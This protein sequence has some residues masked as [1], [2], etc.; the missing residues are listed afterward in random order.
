MAGPVVL[1]RTVPT[2]RSIVSAAWAGQSVESTT[3]PVVSG[4]GR[5]GGVEAMAHHVRGRGPARVRR[6][7]RQPGGTV[8]GCGARA[9]CG[10]RRLR[11][12]GGGARRADPRRVRVHR[13]AA[14]RRRGAVRARRG[15]GGRERGTRS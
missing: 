2:T 3:V 13:G 14:V 5:R 10:R 6:M 11:G 9:G 1:S 15:R 4:A 12:R 7:V 8:A